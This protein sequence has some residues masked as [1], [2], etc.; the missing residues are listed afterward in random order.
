MDLT[1][2]KSAV[3]V[4]LAVS[5]SVCGALWLQWDKPYWSGMAVIVIAMSESLGHA[6]KKGRHRLIGT[7]IG[8]VIGLLLIGF[9]SQE[10][11]LFL[12]S[13]CAVLAVCVFMTSD[14]EYG[15][16]YLT[17]FISCVV[18]ASIGGFDS[19]ITFNILLLRL[20]ETLLGVL[21]YT[22][23]FRVLWPWD[24]EEIF[25]L[26]FSQTQQ[27][28]IVSLDDLTHFLAIEPDERLIKKAIQMSDHRNSIKKLNEYLNVPL[29]GSYQLQNQYR[30]WKM[31][32]K[33][34]SVAQYY[35][36]FILQNISSSK[37]LIKQQR[38]LN[39]AVAFLKHADND[40]QPATV[41]AEYILQAYD[42]LPEE[43]NPEFIRP[44]NYRL[45]A[46]KAL[47]ALSIFVTAILM[48]IYL[49]I[50]D[51]FLFPLNAGIY[52]GLLATMPDRVLKHWMLGYF[53]FGILFIAQ[54]VL[55]MPLMT[56]IWQLASFY[57]INTFIIWRVASK[58]QFIIHRLI[59]G[60]LM[61]MMTMG[62]LHNPPSFDIEMSLI[63]L[64][65][66]MLSLVLVQFYTRLFS[67][68]IAQL[69]DG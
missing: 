31:R 60:N 46:L 64:I 41:T 29:Q 16:I 18:V 59:G 9:L 66:I 43:A 42:N 19:Q 51:S 25:F 13:L 15:D 7:S 21:A 22:L 20:Q 55:I 23:V 67:W 39:K 8:I 1:P 33:A 4:A 37:S 63:M 47:K 68:K 36:T 10:R 35:L 11:F 14:E 12:A 57:F 56:E 61:M 26:L 34:M 44:R 54:Y 32:V 52:A 5:L 28:L 62:A 40:T 45:D 58:P 30:H 65:Y 50:P 48:W 27:K 6:I 49:P 24:T 17:I 53:G 69:A 2:N 3:K 38:R